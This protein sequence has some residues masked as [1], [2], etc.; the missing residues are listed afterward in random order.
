MCPTR[1]VL[2]NYSNRCFVR[3]NLT[4]GHGLLHDRPPGTDLLPSRVSPAHAQRARDPF[5]PGWRSWATR[6]ALVRA[7]SPRSPAP[8]P[9]RP[10]NPAWTS[11]SEH[12]V[13]TRVLP[14]RIMPLLRPFSRCTHSDRPP[15]TRLQAL[16]ASWPSRPSSWW[17]GA[18]LN[19]RHHGYEQC[20]LGFDVPTRLSFVC[21]HMQY[22]LACTRYAHPVHPETSSLQCVSK[23]LDELPPENEARVDDLR[24]PGK[25]RRMTSL[26]ALLVSL[27]A[28]GCGPSEQ[29]C[30]DR[31]PRQPHSVEADSLGGCSAASAGTQHGTWR[32]K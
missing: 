12:T 20:A 22:A 7:R 27:A 4:W 13:T 17:L 2:R 24:E 5:L 32:L 21:M 3:S 14:P 16:P 19:R 15:S 10:P 6:T 25:R 18:D 11:R 8:P 30:Q 1:P 26:L 9:P 29:Y 31:A 23:K 28:W